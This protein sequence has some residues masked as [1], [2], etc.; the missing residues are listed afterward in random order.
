M[1]Q[2]ALTQGALTQGALAQGGPLTPPVHVLVGSRNPVKINATH[3]AFGRYFGEVVVTGLEVAS[4]VPDQPVEEQ[5][6]EGAAN[7]AAALWRLNAEQRLSAAFC[8]GIEGGMVRL[9]GIW[10]GLGC[11]CVMDEQGRTGYGTSGLFELPPGLAAEMLN[12]AELGTLVDRLME[13]T[14][15]KQRGGAVAYLT[16]DV[17]DRT[18]L[19]VHGL[20]LALIP[21][22]HP[23]LYA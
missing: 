19:Y 14:G 5:T 18:A 9:N 6:F 4:G 22:L 1:T 10:F 12:G 13:E 15:T 11:M 3:E 8:V 20:L 21:L 16:D 23:E 17:V 7:R 2:A